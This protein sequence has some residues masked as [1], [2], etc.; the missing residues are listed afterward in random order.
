MSYVYKFQHALTHPLEQ[1]EVKVLHKE[2]GSAKR[3]VRRTRAGHSSL[4]VEV[5][6]ML[7]CSDVE[8]SIITSYTQTRPNRLL[9][10]FLKSRTKTEICSLL[11]YYAAYIRNS[12]PTFRN[13]P[14]D[15]IFEGQDMSHRQG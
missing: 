6:R 5:S 8:Q 10:E 13:K 4:H 12:L 2:F 3:C 7:T 15:P 9:M 14:I 1:H 11:R